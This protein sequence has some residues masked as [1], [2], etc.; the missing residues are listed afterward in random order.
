MIPNINIKIIMI[1][2][3]IIIIGMD[4]HIMHILGLIFVLIYGYYELIVCCV[5]GGIIRTAINATNTT[6]TKFNFNYY[7]F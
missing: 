3:N 4:V 7:Y 2:L 1:Y 6:Y 5:E